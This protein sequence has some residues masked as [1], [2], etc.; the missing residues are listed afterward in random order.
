MWL[1][2][3]VSVVD[4]KYKSESNNNKMYGRNEIEKN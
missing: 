3:G 1:S 2:I 4:P